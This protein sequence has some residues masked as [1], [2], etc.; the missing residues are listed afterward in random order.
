MQHNKKEFEAASYLYNKVIKTLGQSHVS[1]FLE[2]LR[3]TKNDAALEIIVPK[4]D[5]EF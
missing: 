3:E 4:L 2:I 5:G 1:S